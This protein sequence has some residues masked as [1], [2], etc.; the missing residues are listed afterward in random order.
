M[1]EQIN[2]CK[3]CGCEK[4]LDE[5][6]DNKFTKS[7][8]TGTCKECIK[9]Y[10]IDRRKDEEIKKKKNEY[11]LKYYHKNKDVFT[12]KRKIYDQNNPDHMKEYNKINLKKNNA[13]QRR[14]YYNDPNYKIR[15]LMSARIKLE[16]KGRVKTLRTL[17]L[18][19]CSLEECRQ[20][21]EQQFLPEMNWKNWGPVWELDHIL[22]C[23]SFDL[24]NEEEQKKCFHFSNYQ[25][26]FKDTKTAEL[27]GYTDYIGNRNKHAKIL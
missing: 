26:L 23:V 24:T 12:E 11:D 17:D 3:K 7:G 9:Q 1:S 10:Q 20:H 14:R 22:P 8:K 6:Y 5:F 15:V 16:L 25:P 18:I 2:K 19:G 27:F 13:T 21:I 4:I